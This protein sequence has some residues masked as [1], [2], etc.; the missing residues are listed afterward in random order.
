MSCLPWLTD[1]A[2]AGLY[3][4]KGSWYVKTQSPADDPTRDVSGQLALS[5][6]IPVGGLAVLG[7]TS[8]PQESEAD[9]NS[10]LSLLT[11]CLSDTLPPPSDC[12][13][14]TPRELLLVRHRSK[15][16]AARAAEGLSSGTQSWRDR[17]KSLLEPLSAASATSPKGNWS[18]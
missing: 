8:P 5:A 12:A 15:S 3:C 7:G 1:S 4:G 14:P 11:V 13:S 2:C 6:V 9:D 18:N 17:A 10:L 16:L